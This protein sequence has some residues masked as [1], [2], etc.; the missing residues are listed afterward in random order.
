MSKKKQKSGTRG[1]R[2]QSGASNKMTWIL[3]LVLVGAF[4]LWVGQPLWE[5]INKTT[6]PEASPE[7][8]AKGEALYQANCLACHGPSAQGQDLTSQKG[9]Q[10]PDGTFIAPALNGKGHAWHHPPNVLFK[11]IKEG[12]PAKESPMRGFKEKLS[13][14]DIHAVMAYFQSMWPVEIKER[15]AQMKH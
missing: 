6:M 4:G 15:Y 14:K 5:K 12:S 7:V 11:I 2:Q 10:R 13:D 3:V 9:G 8:I 1:G